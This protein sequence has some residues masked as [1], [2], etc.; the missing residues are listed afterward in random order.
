MS[1]PAPAGKAGTTPC[2]SSGMPSSRDISG[3]FIL[4]SMG[5]VR[6]TLTGFPSTFVISY[7]HSRAALSAASSNGGTLRVMRAEVTLPSGPTTSSRITMPRMPRA[8]AS[9]G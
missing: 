7:S 4:N 9:G 1:G 5:T 6:I 3:S 2:R 8:W